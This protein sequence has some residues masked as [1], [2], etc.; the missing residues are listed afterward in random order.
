MRVRNRIIGGA[1]VMSVLLLIVLTSASLAFGE[2]WETSDQAAVLADNQSGLIQNGSGALLGESSEEDLMPPSETSLSA[3]CANIADTWNA[4]HTGEQCCTIPELGT[5]CEP[6]YGSSTVT[7]SQSGCNINF[8]TVF[9]TYFYDGV[10]SG[11]GTIN[12]NN[13]QIVGQWESLTPYYSCFSINQN[14]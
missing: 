3:S 12:G 10:L 1:R 6:I 5:D 13:I 14:S 9:D 4:S 2:N 7:L 11:A 8:K